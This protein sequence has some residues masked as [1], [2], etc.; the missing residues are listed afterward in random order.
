MINRYVL[1]N[2]RPPS[3]ALTEE[4]SSVLREAFAEPNEEWPHP[5]LFSQSTGLAIRQHL[6][7]TDTG[8]EVILSLTD[9]G[10][11]LR[12]ASRVAIAD[13]DLSVRSYNSLTAASIDTLDKLLSWKPAQ[14]MELPN[15][16][17]K[18]LNEIT[19]IV[20]QLGYTSFGDKVGSVGAQRKLPQLEDCA[21]L[22][23]LL[24]MRE[25]ALEGSLPERFVAHGWNSVADLAVHS[26]EAIA[27]LA[28]LRIEEKLQFERALHVLSLELPFE[29]PAW[30]L[31][32]IDA[33]RPA[34]RIELEQ[35]KCSLSDGNHKTSSWLVS[36]LSRS[37]NEELLQLI[38]RSYGAGKRKIVSDLLGL[39][40]KDPLTLDEVAK[41]QTPSMT[42][43]RVRQVALPITDV[44][45][46][47]GRN[48]PRLLKAIAT[49]KQLAPCSLKRA[50]QELLD[51]K[52]LDAPMT[53]AAILRLARRSGVEH[54]LVQEGDALLTTDVARL[55]AAVISAAGKL[56]SRWGVA[57]WREIDPMV[58]E[59]VMPA[60]K[61]QL[62]EV[63]WLDEEQR[64]FVLSD[65][66]NS[67][68]NRLARILKVTP[69]LNVAEAY[70][71]AFRDSRMEMG[72][73][74]E[75][76]FAAFC[77][78]WPWCS[79]ED[80]EVMARA[81]LPPSEVSGDDLLVL[82]L[83]EIGHPVR[84]RELMKRA[85]E[86]G[87]SPEMVT[88]AL[89]Y[90]NVIASANGYFAVIG[91]PRLKDPASSAPIAPAEILEPVKAPEDGGLVPDGSADSFAGLLMLALEER[92]AMLGLTAPWSVSELRLSQIDRD[93]LLAWGRSA[94]WNFRDDSG[95][96]QT[97]S[98]EKVRKR[99]ALGLAF[100][101][102]ASEA[103]RRFG[104]SGSA[105]PAIE[106]ALG[107][108]QQNLFMFRAGVPKL[109][110]REAV[111]A[112]CRTFGLRHGFEDVSQQVWV[113]T[114]G[115][116]TGL[117][118]SQIPGL[119]AMLAEP[120][121]LQPVAINLL[122]DREGPNASASFR[123]S[124]KLLQDIR[125]GAVSKKDGLERFGADAWLSPFLADQLLE[126]CLT[127]RQWRTHDAVESTTITKEEAYQYF[128]APVLRWVSDEAYLE[129]NLN[130]LA[131]PWHESAALIVFCDDPFR[132][133]RVPIENDRWQLPAGPLRVP[134]AN[135]AEAGFN[136]KLLQGKEEVFASWMYAGLP[137]EA[138]FTFFRATGATV[139]SADDVPQSEEVVLLHAADV[140]VTGLNAP[141]IF[142]A[143][144]RGAYRLTRLPAGAVTRVQLVGPDGQTL[145][146]LPLA[147]EAEVGNA[148]LVFAIRGGKW[149]TVVDVAL[150]DL[151]FT[152]ER[153][154]LHSG[155]VVPIERGNGHAV[156]KTSPGVTRAQIAQ[157]QGS[158]GVHRRSTRVKLQHLGAD[159]GAALETDGDWQP[160]DGSATLDAATLRTQRMLA[161]VKG[162]LGTDQ[163]VCWME[164]SRTLAG[165]RNMGMPLIGVHGLGESLNVVRGTYNSSQTEVPVASAVTDG[166]FWRSVQREADES[167]SAHLPFEGPLED[168]HALWMWTED[169]P[170]P[171]ELPREQ[172]LKTGFS[173][174]WSGVA[175]TPV[176][177][178]AFSFDGT[179]VGSVIQPERL[180][181]VIQRLS[182]V[183]WAEAAMWLRWWHAP[184]LHREM[185]DTVADRVREH[186]VETLKAWLLPAHGS[187]GLIFDE[188]RE[189][190]WA[191]A[192]REFLWG[193]RP[194]PNQAA[195]LVKALGIW[196]GD[197]ERDS[198]QP[199]SLEAV[200]L[201][202]RMS[203]ILLA[204][205]TTQALPRMYS[206][207][208]PQLAVLLG[209][210]LETI[211]PNAAE[212]GFRLEL[213]CERY[214]KGESRLDGRFILT[215][216][217]GAARALLRGDPQDTHNLRIAFHQAGLR[218]LI[219]TALLRDAFEHWQAG[220]ED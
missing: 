18:S 8:A 35:L 23:C 117:Q 212:S 202:A 179:R 14:L 11:T 59:V 83:R 29:L 123:A 57:D 80:D 24:Q 169:S 166:G 131:P 38:P 172:M 206:Y 211:N 60:V 219:S 157:L 100:L 220:T 205:T 126:Q 41:A 182:G 79:V 111:E 37:L 82:L 97:K 133:E 110:V 181:G 36:P 28:G 98:G 22:A 209:R 143:V 141:P 62:R 45:E 144:L 42:R 190:A 2:K 40:G 156:V 124:W 3:L 50:E 210:V 78:L 84:R 146:S 68:A 145:W 178:W 12:L 105:W 30:F 21:P 92:V 136:F 207:P 154:R 109:S 70:R 128:S 183:Q 153:L 48:L 27:G 147:E 165:L 104:G 119:G 214:A 138:P 167:W 17:R 58:P 121:Y 118:C 61:A 170:L 87:L 192:A 120:E 152:A 163:D 195:E 20:H 134:L 189:E 162:V 122:L 65:W 67:L 114:V 164:G 19:D 151:P 129:Y 72:R 198:Q 85:L 199:P 135:R 73:L 74:P 94:K 49:L 168:G 31:H 34:F 113:R 160:L 1:W 188:L 15:F 180:G 71:G 99:T 200:G 43:E 90:S 13:L 171:R 175:S 201:L 7:E 139:Q 32:N 197:I 208:K 56:S 177:G 116:Q 47:R 115:L 75:T 159:F 149:G 132:K 5:G 103:V 196:T 187:S 137:R 176:F 112:A 6:A 88:Y 158:A 173:L 55:V 33:L 52:I 10:P 191:A 107:E 93:R 186:P 218:E 217:I 216:L 89:S 53:V 155:Q 39:G 194:D 101:L 76:L 16:G 106:H 44:L 193:W 26:A 150:P 46:T 96:Y 142:R 95:S 54:G 102:F 51:E 215:S 66:E 203:P 130:E 127:A 140:R 77:R 108:P 4:S 174:R 9:G 91:D 69:R 86:Q 185:R 64:Y 184:V 63:V 204:D 161:K 125:Q 213:A 25:L 81:G 148:E